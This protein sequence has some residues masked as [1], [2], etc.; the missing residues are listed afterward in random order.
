MKY[1]SNHICTDNKEVV[2][3]NQYQYF[4]SG[5]VCDVTVLEDNS[6]SETIEFHLRIDKRLR[7]PSGGEDE[8][9]CNAARGLHAYSGMWRLYPLGEYIKIGS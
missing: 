7:W 6:D 4:E 5:M 1:D 9:T 3:G 2:V 8:F